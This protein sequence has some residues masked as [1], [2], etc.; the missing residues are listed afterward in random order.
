MHGDC[1]DCMHDRMQVNVLLHLAK[2]VKSMPS[3][4]SS[5][6]YLCHVVVLVLIARQVQAPQI[7]PDLEDGVQPNPLPCS[8]GL[9]IPG[10]KL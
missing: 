8:H 2:Q 5:S 1:L 6:H 10:A 3:G 9:H 7:G 4:Y